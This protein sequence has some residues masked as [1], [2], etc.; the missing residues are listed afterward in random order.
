MGVEPG[1]VS[2]RTLLLGALA[3]ASGRA[4][5]PRLPSFES[6]W[7]RY[8]DPLTEFEVYR[9]TQ[10]EYTSELPAYYNRGI[11]RN[12]AWMI[13]TC[14][15]TGSPQ[16]FRM[17][18][19]NGETHQLTDVTDLVP[20]S[21][22][23]TPDNRTVCYCSGRTLCL[24]NLATLRVREFYEFPE[25][26][27]FASGPNTDGV[28]IAWVERSASGSR[29]RLSSLGAG[30]GRTL[31]EARE[32]LSNPILRPARQQ[33]LYRSG[34]TQVGL[35]N[36][37]GSRNRALKLAEGGVGAPNWSPDGSLLLYL[38][39]PVDKTRLNSIH[40]FNPETG[41]DKAVAKTSQFVAFGFNR[42][43]SVFAGASRNAGSPALLLLL[44]NT[45][46][47]M[48]ICEHKASHPEQVTPVFAP[49]SQRVYFQSDRHGKP[50]IYCMHI[51]RLV[52]KIE[53]DK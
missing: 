15:R 31:M 47:E 33:V 20:S 14:D 1:R 51:E 3:A 11:A 2:R 48:T 18:L 4:A 41:E 17:D 39:F 44:R 24:L 8:A 42:N 19:G 23:M 30:G 43:T 10:P 26:W 45:Q 53:G 9:L 49:D 52:E 38:N 40:E 6:D 7:R 27:E 12:S 32:A 5:S 36:L 29:L 37:D 25:S 22:T 21:V 50:A 28:R 16:I 34:E 13:F 46:R 35:T